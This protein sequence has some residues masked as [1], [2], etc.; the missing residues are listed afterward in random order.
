MI[1]VNGG[2]AAETVDCG[3]GNDTIYV[4]PRDSDGGRS[5]RVP[6]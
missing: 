3:G 5:T 6:A 2:S 4:N 1:Y